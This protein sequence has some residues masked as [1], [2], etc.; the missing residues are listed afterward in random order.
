MTVVDEVPASPHDDVDDAGPQAT[1][2]RWGGWR[3][4]ALL[5]VPVAIPLVAVLVG[6][7]DETWYPTGDLAQA[8]LH[9]RGFPDHPPLVGAAGRIGV[10]GV[11][12]GQGSHPGPSLWVAMA[13]AYFLSGQTSFGLMAG[14][15]TLHAAAIV[16][17]VVAARRLG[18]VPLAA[19]V[20]LLSVVLV[21]ASGSQFLVEPWNPWAAILPF[22][23]F[24]V[25]VAG[26]VAG[27]RKLLPWAVLV[28]SHCIQSHV[29][30][31]LLVGALVL[32]ALV[33]RARIDGRRRLLRPVAWS[34]VVGVVVW[35]PPVLDQL[36][37]EHG[38]LEILWEHFTNPDAPYVGFGDAFRG[39]AGEFNL[40]GGWLWGE[41]HLP[42]D[43]PN[44]PG[45]AGM[46]AV[47]AGGVA[48]AW[49][50]R[51]RAALSLLGTVVAAAVIGL[52]SMSRIFG[53][54]YDYVVRWLWIITGLGVAGS[55][56]TA[57][58][59]WASSG[60]GGRGG[61]AV[62]DRRR[63]LAGAVVVSTAVGVLAAVQIVDDEL[64]SVRNSRLIGGAIGDVEDN[65]DPDGRYLVRWHDPVSLG[66]VG[67]GVL[68]ELER[69]GFTVGVDEWG[70][71]AALPHR[72]LYENTATGVLWVITGDSHIEAF[73]ERPDARLLGRYDQRTPAERAESDRLL[74][75]MEE[76]LREIGRPDLIPALESQYGLAS[77]V[78]GDAPVPQ[79]VK[80]L[81]GAYVTLRLP[82]AVFEV[83][84]GSA[85][86]P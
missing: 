25:L 30:Y 26:V 13:P 63:L 67:Y 19:G 45:F 43:E 24:L 85:L 42:T 66:G 12:F 48:V 28:G 50:R 54:F 9:V 64:P 40:A 44:W 38:N 39:F 46:V 18:G 47:V 22:L 33:V 74:A 79:D 58:R 68:L 71:A 57:G 78:I 41:G 7:G 84:P 27:D 61:R 5:L 86:Y 75:R 16:G 6:M 4:V 49:R 72:V 59:A 70:S 14:M 23:C 51:D 73:A 52:V 29:G 69:R 53:E 65:L 56:W 15:V 32:G 17:A 11:P 20:A 60:A 62:L 81:A 83:P 80:D 2:S 82:L 10:I 31:A 3:V 34:V 37:R 35:L 36:F 76:R 1:D 8:E 77:F 55:L 21:R